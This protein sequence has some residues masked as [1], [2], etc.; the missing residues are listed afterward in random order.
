MITN[1]IK[2]LLLNY[3][4]GILRFPLP[5][6]SLTLFTFLYFC[7]TNSIFIQIEKEL[8]Y[9]FFFSCSFFFYFCVNLFFESHNIRLRHYWLIV[10]GLTVGVS[11]L[12]WYEDLTNLFSLL[13]SS[14][15]LLS[16]SPF[17]FKDKSNEDYIY[18]SLSLGLKLCL[19]FVRFGVLSI[20]LCLTVFGVKYLFEI[21]L[22]GNY[23]STYTNI[24]LLVC[25]WGGVLYWLSLIPKNF[26]HLKEIKY[27]NSI[28]FIISYLLIPGVLIYFVLLYLYIIKIL[29]NWSLPKGLVA[30]LVLAFAIAGALVH[31]LSCPLRNVALPVVKIVYKYFYYALIGPLLLLFVGASV[32]INEYGFTEQRYYLLLAGFWFLLC[33]LY[34]IFR[35]KPKFKTIVFVLSILLV[36]SSFGPWSAISVSTK[37]QFSRLRS[38]LE[39]NHLLVNGVIKKAD[40]A[41]L[42][43]SHKDKDSIFSIMHYLIKQEKLDWVKVWFDDEESYV[44]KTKHRFPDYL[45][46][47]EDI[48]IS[49]E[50]QN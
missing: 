34:F 28:T 5:F 11:Y 1:S 37:S 29:V 2:K 4:E 30:S 33:S 26:F 7:A 12:C 42:S 41:K 36:F 6:I 22:T 44:H 17:I 32:R 14:V 3:K 8:R 25:F 35:R 46:V 21:D 9:Y 18:F 40:P 10:L 23:G 20:I 48:G 43:I 27:H 15:F 16:V 19:S 50:K 24:F 31:F 47:V 49:D 39:K 45:R 13:V 38:I